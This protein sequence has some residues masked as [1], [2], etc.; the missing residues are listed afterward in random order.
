MKMNQKTA[1]PDQRRRNDLLLLVGVLAVVIIFAVIFFATRREGAYAAI[2]Q[3]GT[4]IARHS[5]A[6]DRQIQIQTEGTVT[7]L[8]VIEGGKARITRADCPDQ[9]CVNHRPVSKVGETVVCLPREL[10]IK[11]VGNETVQGPDMVV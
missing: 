2:L 3:N 7:H 8:L 5:L 4:E 9:I 10:V 6:E 11:I 1:A